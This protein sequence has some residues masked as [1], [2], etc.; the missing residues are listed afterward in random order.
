MHA[1]NVNFQELNV[2]TMVELTTI[3]VLTFHVHCVDFKE[4]DDRTRTT[5]EFTI[6][7]SVFV[8]YVNIWECNYRI[9]YS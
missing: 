8:C 5:V 9:Y 3:I 1:T 6:A 7:T 2:C 4:H